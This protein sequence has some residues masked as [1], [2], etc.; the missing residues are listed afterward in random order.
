MKVIKEIVKQA[1]SHFFML[2]Y[3]LQVVDMRWGVRDEATDDH[4]GP[5]LCMREI[6]NCQKLS[7]G[8]NFV[9][10]SIFL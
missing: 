1:I 5:A 7:L 3:N 6:Q 4:Q 10:I 9:V 8:P 2:H